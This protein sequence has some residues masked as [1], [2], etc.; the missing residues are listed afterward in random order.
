MLLREEPDV[1]LV[2]E[3]DVVWQSVDSDPI[4]GLPG[5]VYLPEFFDFELVIPNRLVAG[6]AQADRRYGGGGALSYV[7]V[8]EGAV[9]AKLLNVN[10]MRECDGLIG[11]LVKSEHG[12]RQTKPRG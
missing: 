4:D 9:K 12:Q 7:P 6:H 5:L 1:R 10:W 8:A 11:S 3:L 2:H